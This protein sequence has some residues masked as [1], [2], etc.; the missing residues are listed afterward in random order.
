M[1]ISKH[2]AID[3]GGEREPGL[4]LRSPSRG[5]SLG[6]AVGTWQQ[7]MSAPYQTREE[8]KTLTLQSAGRGVR[9]SGAGGT[10]QQG[11]SMPV[12]RDPCKGEKA[13]THTASI[14]GYRSTCHRG[15]GRLAQ[16]VSVPVGRESFMYEDLDTHRPLYSEHRQ[17]TPNIESTARTCQTGRT[18]GIESRKFV[19]NAC[20]VLAN[21][22][23][24][25]MHSERWPLYLP[26]CYLLPDIPHLFGRRGSVEVT[27][28]A[29]WLDPHKANRASRAFS[30]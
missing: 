4:T 6:R 17:A 8:S 24:T 15:M 22:L 30:N 2:D 5:V 7:N 20:D 1:H 21:A 16:G 3:G 23:M 13:E 19:N 11:M 25:Y 9:A 26:G 29:N 27:A 28:H 18:P 10:W 14:P 12:V